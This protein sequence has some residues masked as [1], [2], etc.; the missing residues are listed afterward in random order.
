MRRALS[1][2]LALAGCTPDISEPPTPVDPLEDPSAEPAPTPIHVAAVS[3]RASLLVDGTTIDGV[4]DPLEG[5]FVEP[6]L[7]VRF[8]GGPDRCSVTFT[9]PG[10]GPWAASPVEWWSLVDHGAGPWTETVE[11]GL[12]L[13]PDQGWTAVSTCPGLFAGDDL[14]DAVDLALTLRPVLG[15]GTANAPRRPVSVGGLGESV[16]PDARIDVWQVTDGGTLLVD[17]NGERRPWTGQLEYALPFA[18]YEAELG[19][20]ELAF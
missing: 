7:E 9:P 8:A 15:V 11:E 13:A 18:W 6:T 16:N 10:A 14:V 19:P 20:F 12:G 5:R 3:L 4:Y 2:L 17:S 1:L